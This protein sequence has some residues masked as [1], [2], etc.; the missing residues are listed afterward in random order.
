MV[1][2]LL[3]ETLATIREDVRTARTKDPAATGKLTVALLYSGVHAVWGYRIAHTLWNRG[4]RFSAR[5]LSQLVR[6][7]TGV[8]IHP[9]AEIGRRLFIDHGAGVVI[10]ETAEIGDDVLLYHG[11]TLGGDSM[12]REKR[13]TTLE[14]GVTIGANATLIG[15]ITVGETATVGAGSVAVDDVR[16]NATVVGVPA[17]PLDDDDPVR[18]KRL[19]TELEG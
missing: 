14:S 9:A 11:V 17:E 1:L 7:L 6:F 8:E 13:H 2:T 5:F 16:T 19:R 3:R 15:D 18:T 10:G 4:F 12:R